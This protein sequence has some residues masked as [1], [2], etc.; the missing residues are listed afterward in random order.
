MAVVVDVPFF[1]S[2]GPMEDAGHISN[3]DIVWCVVD[4]GETEEGNRCAA[5]R[6][7]DGLYHP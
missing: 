4:Y 5:L 7:R 1:N 6:L 3:S 2:L